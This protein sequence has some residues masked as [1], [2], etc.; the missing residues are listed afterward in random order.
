MKPCDVVYDAIKVKDRI[1]ASRQI[2][3]MMITSRLIPFWL[4]I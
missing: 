3:S 2:T 1:A 4:F